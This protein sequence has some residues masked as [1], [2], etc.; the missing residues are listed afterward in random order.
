[1]GG[2]PVIAPQQTT[3]T[4]SYA[5]YSATACYNP[6]P[7]VR[8]T[9]KWPDNFTNLTDRRSQLNPTGFPA[10]KFQTTFDTSTKDPS[11][12]QMLMYSLS[13]TEVNPRTYIRLRQNLRVASCKTDELAGPFT[14]DPQ[15]CTNIQRD[16][17]SNMRGTCTIAPY[18]DLRKIAEVTNDQGETLE[19]FWTPYTHNVGCEFSSTTPN[20]GVGKGDLMNM[21]EFLYVLK[22]RDA[23]DPADQLDCKVRWDE[24]SLHNNP[25]SHY[26]DVYIAE[27]LYNKLVAFPTGEYVPKVTTDPGYDL[28]RQNYA[29]FRDRIFNCKEENTFTPMTD[30]LAFP[31]EYLEKPFVSNITATGANKILPTD[32]WER[33][34]YQYYIIETIGLPA[35]SLFHT[36]TLPGPLTKCTTTNPAATPT[37]IPLGVGAPTC[38][39]PI[40]SIALSDENNQSVTFSA[41]VRADKGNVFY[42]KTDSD[43]KIYEYILTDREPPSVKEKNSSLQLTNLE[44]RAAAQWT[45]ATP[46]CKPAIYLYPPKPMDLNVKLAIDGKLT[47]SDPEYN[48]ATGWNVSANPDGRIINKVA[49]PKEFPYLYYEAD[50]NDVTA[51]EEGFVWA[52]EDMKVKLTE[53]LTTVGFN[54]KEITDFLAYWLP[55]VQESPYYF[56]TLLPES[57]INEKEALQLSTQPDTIIRARVIFEALNSPVSVKPLSI[58]KHVRSGFVLTDWGG[59]IVGQ[60]CKVE[61]VQ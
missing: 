57:V 1:M 44:F 46:V 22:K 58:P 50:L 30:P 19:V 28:Y 20:C 4:A 5:P 43:P 54:D 40:G 33:T 55:R 34:N 49:D 23:F 36:E 48:T 39:M 17:A 60:S 27:D 16:G 31:L 52:K 11:C 7:D 32:T 13:G 41:F 10:S 2:Q 26:F 35:K 56:V 21:K 15:I 61:N 6:E 45:W 12:R 25:C 29:M 3:S 24:K 8:F 59:S 42:L 37:G 9:L 51:P 47:V 38:Y 18:P 14:S 53:L